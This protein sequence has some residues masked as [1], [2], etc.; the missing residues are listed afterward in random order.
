M[1]ALNNLN[2]AT[3]DEKMILEYL[4]KGQL[5]ESAGD[6]ENAV[7]AFRWVVE[8]YPEHELAVYALSR[9]VA[10][11][12]Q[13]DQAAAELNFIFEL[14]EKFSGTTLGQQAL[15]WEPFLLAKAKYFEAAIKRSNQLMT[16]KAN[17][18]MEKDLLFQQIML[19]YY[20]LNDVNSA[21]QSRDQFLNQFSADQRSFELRSL[22]FLFKTKPVFNRPV[23]AG[24]NGISNGFTLAQN[25]PN[26]FNTATQI[27]YQ[28]DEPAYITLKIFNLLGQE[29][30]T[31]TDRNQESGS[32]TM[33]WNGK[34]SNGL[35][36]P[37]GIYIVQI[38]TVNLQNR[39]QVLENRK[40]VLLY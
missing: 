24:I 21:S 8:N 4:K 7:S 20:E 19:Y 36:V 14:A 37:A 15:Y 5:A 22:D 9:L 10:C 28:L 33:R 38:L 32:Y 30:L 39:Q 13:Q 31:L 27:F 25:Y 17:T 3:D 16:E 26:P 18:E 29:I 23:T 40:M 2:Q 6:F 11:R 35:S 12:D 34:D 1:Q